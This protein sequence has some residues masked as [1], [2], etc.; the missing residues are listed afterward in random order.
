[1]D[2]TDKIFAGDFGLVELAPKDTLFA[3][4]P[5]NNNNHPLN[6]VNTCIN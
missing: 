1:M 2:L 3:L 6:A 5:K 4:P